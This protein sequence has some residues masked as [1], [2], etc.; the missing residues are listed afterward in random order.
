MFKDNDL[1]ENLSIGSDAIRKGDIET[2]KLLDNENQ[3][4]K[5]AVVGAREAA[6][7]G[8]IEMLRYLF[9]RFPVD[10]PNLDPCGQLKWCYILA[11]G[12]GQTEV[13]SWLIDNK[14]PCCCYPGTPQ[15]FLG[16]AWKP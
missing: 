4:D 11:I 6:G 10:T 15:I 13:V 2:L 9:T 8:D 1:W 3:L 14:I 5:Q 12:A 7:N 16:I